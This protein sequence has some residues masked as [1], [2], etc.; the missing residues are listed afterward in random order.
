ECVGVCGVQPVPRSAAE[1][2]PTVATRGRAA[3]EQA[4]NDKCQQQRK[5]DEEREYRKMK[6]ERLQSVT[7]AIVDGKQA[8]NERPVGLIR[9]QRTESRSVEE[10]EQ[11]VPHLADGRVVYDRVGVV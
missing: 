10:E 9:R 8:G 6:P 5:R 2:D 7:E 11:D 1:G 4:V 3:L